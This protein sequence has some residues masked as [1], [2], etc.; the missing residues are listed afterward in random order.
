MN[1]KQ[2]HDIAQSI[3]ES[4]QD[5]LITDRSGIYIPQIACQDL[6]ICFE[7]CQ[8]DSKSI[9]LEGPENEYY[10]EAWDDVLNYGTIDG[11]LLHQDGDLWLIDYDKRSELIEQQ[12]DQSEYIQSLIE[13]ISTY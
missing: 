6:D 11:K 3:I 9:C 4:T 1:T 13:D 2:Y 12:G 10:W 8:E 7:N 5:L